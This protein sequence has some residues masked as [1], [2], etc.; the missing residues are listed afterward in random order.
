MAIIMLSGARA[1]KQNTQGGGERE[2]RFERLKT[3]ASGINASK[4]I[5]SMVT[6]L[7]SEKIIN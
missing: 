4:K 6:D 7:P 2:C 5:H 3:G 1:H